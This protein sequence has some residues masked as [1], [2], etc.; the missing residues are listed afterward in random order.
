MTDFTAYLIYIGEKAG[1][2]GTVRISTVNLAKA[3]GVSQQTASRNL[4]IMEKLGYIK[5]K[6]SVKGITLSLDERGVEFQRKTRATLSKIFKPRTSLNGKVV[7]GIGEGKY[8]VKVYSRKIR[9]S[10]G[11]KPYLG[12][13]D[14]KT[15]P[16]F[17]NEFIEQL[18]PIRISGFSTKTRSFGS[19]TCY[20]IKINNAKA[21]IVVPERSHHPK[22]IIEVI[23]PVYL[24]KKFSLKDNS[25]LRLD[26]R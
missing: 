17:K 14:L 11:F 5:R 18:T 2:Y 10:L 7:S 24:R 20:M 23:A 13:L 1:L 8:Y 3:L 16:V 6:S 12:T 22:N 4:M 25:V 15:N 21:A 9:E 26:L 19:I